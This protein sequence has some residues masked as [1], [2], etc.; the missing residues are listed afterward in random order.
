VGRD[1]FL[2]DRSILNQSIVR[3]TNDII[4]HPWKGPILALRMKGIERDPLYYDHII[5]GDFR[6]VI[7]YFFIYNDETVKKTNQTIKIK[8][9]KIKVNCE[10][11]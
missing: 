1:I 7:D 4:S 6:D 9:K 2:I 11:D 3:A 8:I 5:I 10:G